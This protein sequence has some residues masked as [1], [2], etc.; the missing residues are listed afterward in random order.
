MIRGLHEVLSAVWKSGSICSDWKQ[1]LV[2]PVWKGRGD[3][4]DCNS[5][6]GIILLSLLGKVLPHLLLTRVR[7]HLLKFQ[8]LISS[9][10]CQ[11]FDSV[12]HGMLWDLLRVRRTPVRIIDLISGLYSGTECC[13]LWNRRV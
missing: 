5:Y 3:R 12:H 10:S 2:D 8:R 1:G 6:S 9:G 7:S 4:Q 13:K 11:A